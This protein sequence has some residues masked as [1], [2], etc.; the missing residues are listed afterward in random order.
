MR[1]YCPLQ[2]GSC[3]AIGLET[4][5]YLGP[6]HV[7]YLGLGS[8]FGFALWYLSFWAAIL[9]ALRGL[10]AAALHGQKILQRSSHPF[11]RPPS[12]KDSL[13]IETLARRDHLRF[14][15]A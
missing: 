9:A 5:Y 8:Y 3:C 10:D 11:I 2:S 1:P 12:I 13:A 4:H 6:K 15:K 7:C 14:R